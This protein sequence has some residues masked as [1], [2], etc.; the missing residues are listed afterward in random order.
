[1]FATLKS[2]LLLGLYIFLILCIPVGAYL[3]S[4]Q[5]TVKSRASEG[6]T[7]L[8][9]SP[10]AS[11]KPKSSSSSSTAKELLNALG[12]SELSSS[13]T[14]E[15]ETDSPTI[16]TSFG[17]TLSLKV[18]LEGS[19]EDNQTTKLFIG[20]VEGTLST[21]PK[22]LLNFSVNLPANGTYSNLSLAGLTSGS[23]YT[24]LVKGASQI[25]SSAEFIM[26][27]NVTNLNSGSAINLKSGD[28]NEDNTINS[29][30]YSIVKALLGTTSTSANWNG[31]VDLN[32]DKVINSLDLLIVSKNL[33]T[34]G[35]SGV[36]ISPLNIATPSG[37]LTPQG[38][39]WIWV[40][41]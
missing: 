32:K 28:L 23:K 6:S 37:S 18:T 19:P 15:L 17:P 21:N 27:P 41:K 25:A 36:W 3:V 16:A 13:P 30:D 29:A 14:P 5:Q 24:A 8:K 10:K 4:Q 31:N 38:G 7:T 40:P 12:S 39:Y 2:R 33:G 1:M 22:F 9:P 26:S 11:P 34:T 20:I 35:A